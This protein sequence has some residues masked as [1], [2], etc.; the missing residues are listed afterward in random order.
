MNLPR[1]ASAINS[2]AFALITFGTICGC[3]LSIGLRGKPKLWMEIE[4]PFIG[5]D[6]FKL[7]NCAFCFILKLTK[8]CLLDPKI[9]VLRCRNN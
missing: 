3:S 4:L 1:L 6:N 9:F 2:L 8:L 7:F 5:L